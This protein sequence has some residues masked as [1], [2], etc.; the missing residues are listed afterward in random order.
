MTKTSYQ[1][2]HAGDRAVEIPYGSGSLYNI[3]GINTNECSSS[4]PPIIDTDKGVIFTD[5]IPGVEIRY[6]P[7]RSTN[8][9]SVLA[10]FV[11]QSLPEKKPAIELAI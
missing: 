9:K 5:E 10:I 2:Y 6:D 4:I 1:V 11:A 3:R 7:E 8:E